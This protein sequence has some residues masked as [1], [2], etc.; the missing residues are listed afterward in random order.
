MDPLCIWPPWYTWY[1]L[2]GLSTPPCS[3]TLSLPFGTGADAGLS[4]PASFSMPNPALCYHSVCGR[5]RSSM[6]VWKGVMTKILLGVFALFIFFSS[7]AVYQVRDRMSNAR[8]GSDVTYTLDKNG[9][10]SVRMVEKT[11]FVDEETRKNFD[12]LVARIGNPDAESFG[13]GHGATPH[14]P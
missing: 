11:Y 10:A 5:R 2:G 3:E 4:G 13:K 1:S 14:Q 12:A 9:T 6:L 7:M 8:L